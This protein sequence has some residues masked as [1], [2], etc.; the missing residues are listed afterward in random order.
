MVGGDDERLLLEPTIILLLLL[1]LVALCITVGGVR[2]ERDNDLLDNK[3]VSSSRSF[4]LRGGSWISL[5]LIEVVLGSVTST[6]IFESNNR[7]NG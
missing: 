1:L 2:S 5:S 7:T 6:S 4:L 3:G